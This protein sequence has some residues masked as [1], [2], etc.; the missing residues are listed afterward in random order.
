L[1]HWSIGQVTDILFNKD[2]IQ[3]IEVLMERGTK[4]KAVCYPKLGIQ[5]HVGDTVL[6]NTTAAVLSLGSG[7]G[8]FVHTVLREARR[9]IAE[10][11]QTSSHDSTQPLRKM[12]HIMKLRYTP[13]QMATLSVEEPD[14][15]HHYCFQD[16]GDLQGTPVITGELHSMLPVLVSTLRWFWKKDGIKKE[17]E[18]P[19]IAYIMTDGGALP[20]AWSRN[21]L[22]L[23]QLGW[24]AG[25]V[26]VGHAFGGD[27]EAVNLFTGLIAAR[28]VLK[29]DVIIVLMGPGIVGTS[30]KY[31]FTGIEVAETIHCV[32]S[33]GGLP[34]AIPRISFTDE[35][36]RHSGISHHSLTTLGKVT[37]AS[38]VIPLPFPLD[39]E[40]IIRDQMSGARW[41]EKHV[42]V[43][44]NITTGDVVE[45]LRF[46]PYRITTMG[47][48]F[49]KDFAF[50]QTISAAARFTSRWLA[51][52][53]HV[54]DDPERRLEFASTLE[55]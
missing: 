21:V 53:D 49:T 40:Q 1:I 44:V 36:S 50:F 2:D 48:D 19:R 18:Y 4:E 35:R 6:L 12:G 55:G 25:T 8:H 17:G 9:N 52:D 29:A 34:I 27:L 54:P 16:D 20:I 31:G 7:G 28:R 37:L 14:S 45:A 47:R 43:N 42:I 3:E 15:P 24:L 26:T 33:L 30:T 51:L 32:A 10:T 23:K 5:V 22:Q 39:E 46:Y 41:R 11:L 13:L 38:A